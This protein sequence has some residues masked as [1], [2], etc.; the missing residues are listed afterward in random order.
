MSDRLFARK[1]FQPPG[2]E[3]ALV[4]SVG[5]VFISATAS[6]WANGFVG[7]LFFVLTEYGW[8]TTDGGK[9]VLHPGAHKLALTARYLTVVPPLISLFWG[10]GSRK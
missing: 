5:L 1:A 2:M 8:A 3:K 4:I 7:G 6:I 9:D 10:I